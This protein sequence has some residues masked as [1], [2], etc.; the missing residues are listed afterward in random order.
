MGASELYLLI[1]DVHQVYLHK[2]SVLAL[3]PL[4]RRMSA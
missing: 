3:R 2:N 1:D 4:S